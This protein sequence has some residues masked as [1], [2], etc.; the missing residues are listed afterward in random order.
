MKTYQTKEH[1]PVF[2]VLNDY[3]SLFKSKHSSEKCILQT[4]PAH[5]PQNGPET[6]SKHFKLT[7]LDVTQKKKKK[8][9][10]RS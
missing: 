4:N 1:K 8:C 10:I 7:A 2:M 3:N 9:S 6:I 5:F